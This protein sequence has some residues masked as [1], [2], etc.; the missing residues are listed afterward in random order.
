MMLS[1]TCSTSTSPIWASSAA[2]CTKTPLLLRPDSTARTRMREFLSSRLK[3]KITVCRKVLIKSCWLPHYNARLLFIFGIAVTS[4][5]LEIFYTL[6]AGNTMV[7]AFSADSN[8]CTW[9]SDGCMCVVA[10]INIAR[11]LKLFVEQRWV[12]KSIR[13]DIRHEIK[14]QQ[15]HQA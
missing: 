15:E 13:F 6:R 4:N 1:L 11:A 10:A 7:R 5:Q 3:K 12:I 14:E 2:T 8:Y 9:W